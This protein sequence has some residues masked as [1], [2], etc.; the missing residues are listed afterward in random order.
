MEIRAIQALASEVAQLIGATL[1]ED[2]GESWRAT[3]TTADGI[4]LIFS[5]WNKNTGEVWAYVPRATVRQSEKCGEIGVAFSRG[6]A[7]VAKE[8]EKRLLPDARVKAAAARERWAGL[9]NDAAGLRM[10]ADELARQPHTRAELR[11]PGDVAQRVRFHFYDSAHG[12]L[13]GE[14]SASGYVSLDRAALY[15]PDPKGK[16]IRI[17]TALQS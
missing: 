16:L 11:N 8:I 10:L 14:V 3:I 2:K 4:N 5:T 6:A 1:N 15:G 17:L 9:D 7:A 12:S 13:S